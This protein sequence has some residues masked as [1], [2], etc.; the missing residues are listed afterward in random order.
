[1]KNP[2]INLLTSY[3]QGYVAEVK[4][5]VYAEWN[6]NRFVDS[7][8]TDNGK[9]I[10]DSNWDNVWPKKSVVGYNRPTRGIVRSRL[11]T[12][13]GLY[14]DDRTNAAGFKLADSFIDSK[15]DVR[16]TIASDDDIYRYWSS[17]QV[18][19][20]GASGG[21]YFFPEEQSLSVVYEKSVKVNKVVINL[22]SSE[23][24]PRSFYVQ[25]TT[26]GT[27]WTTIATNPTVGNDGVLT[28]WYSDAWI[29]GN[30]PSNFSN[31][32]QTTIRGIKFAAAAMSKQGAPLSIIEISGRYEQDLSPYLISESHDMEISDVDQISPIGVA[33]SNKASVTLDNTTELFYNESSTSPYAG[34]LD[35][36]VK[37][38]CDYVMSSETFRQW[39]MFT[40]AWNN[41]M[42]LEV[43][44]DLYDQAD[45]LQ[46][47][48]APATFWQG[49]T[50]GSI[51]WRLLDLAGCT[52]WAYSSSLDDVIAVPYYWTDK[53]KSIWE[54]IQSI[55]Q[56]TQMA[57]YFDE[58]GVAQIRSAK[59]V[60]SN[61]PA[62]TWNF[63]SERDGTILA[64]IIEM[65]KSQTFNGSNQ[66]DIKYTETKFTDFN[67]GLPKMEVVW[68][69]DD[70]MV[71]RAC[72][73]SENLPADQMYFVIPQTEADTW[74]LTGMVNVEGEIIS[75]EGK[76]YRA[77]NFFDNGI[78]R[79]TTQVIKSED[80]RKKMDENTPEGIRWRNG[81]TGFFQITKRGDF[82]TTAKAH[83][84]DS[85]FRYTYELVQGGSTNVEHWPGG[86]TRNPNSSTVTL[87][88]RNGMDW[89]SLYT[90]RS[91]ESA[92]ATNYRY[93]CR[94]RIPS[95][96]PANKGAGG[97]YI[98][99]GSN[100]SGFFIN[101]AATE[102]VEATQRASR[103]ELRF[104]VRT[105][106]GMQPM[107]NYIPAPIQINRDTWYDLEAST[108][109]NNDGTMNVI[110]YIDG[111]AWYYTKISANEVAD[112]YGRFGVFIQDNCIVEFDYLYA[113]GTADFG[114]PDGSSFYDNVKGGYIGNYFEKVI[115]YV[116]VTPGKI[117][118]GVRDASPG[119]TG[120]GQQW[121]DEFGPV[122][123]EIRKYEVDF[124]KTPVAHS[125][126]YFSN[127]EQAA[128]PAYF[129]DSFSA[130]FL[131]ANTYRRNVVINGEDTLTFGAD[132]SVDQKIFV[133]GRAFSDEDQQTETVKDEASIR[134]RGLNTTTFESSF[135]QS[136]E[137]A[138]R[139]GDWIVSQWGD[140]TEEY[141]LSI[142]GNPFISI[143][144]IV[145][146]NYPEKE[147]DPTEKFCVVALSGATSEGIETTL[148]VRKLRGIIK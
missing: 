106:D 6:V 148:T 32:S 108:V 47:V 113:V 114:D 59:T 17:F 21:S 119:I 41:Q 87:K 90:L 8:V 27:N 51:I 78:A 98:K 30:K 58:F 102:V 42:S 144:D 73:L 145:T 1:L 86:V 23:A 117:T 33:S 24:L 130:T 141:T 5:K 127:T 25:V 22:E 147:I 63:T 57:I 29:T 10:S 139:L 67:N 11:S 18:T 118:R 3:K 65:G 80:E 20:G 70:T 64:D 142:F 7:V 132:N 93:G 123:H 109:Y 76:M 96:Q 46:K 112:P 140:G 31:E 125:Y 94:M 60:F 107:L 13:T 110:V 133:Y 68:E 124:E 122:V 14:G 4:T 143:G 79:Y 121:L 136:Q 134:K 19:A 105:R 26:N 61:Q 146:I 83:S 50:A 72:P 45:F 99:G 28:I 89:N 131:L 137:S 2:S 9:A 115:P 97:L 12:L 38:W 91:T 39:T 84:I 35:K 56:A 15:P 77:Y 75:Y 95:G 100:N 126:L 129:A 52:A 128:C 138:K 48:L 40:D 53:E 66:V 103:N 135:I 82:G 54:N 37:M 101:L 34:L 111:Q 71:L 16:Y 120:T 104:Q 62:A 44:V 85:K 74:P 116:A 88:G 49:L 43:S 55:A 92:Y 69:P 36:N 81:Y